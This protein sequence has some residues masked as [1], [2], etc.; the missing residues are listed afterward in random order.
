M[1]H[2]LSNLRV[3]IRSVRRHPAFIAVSVGVLALGIGVSTAI[4]SAMYSVLLKPLPYSEQN[5]LFVA[6]KG[7]SQSGSLIGEMSYPEFRDWVNRSTSFDSLAAMPTTVYGYEYVLTGLGLPIEIPSGR[8]SAS[9]FSVLRMQPLLGRVFSATDDTRGAAPT[10]I[11][12]HSLWSAQFSSDPRV[13]GTQIHLSGVA[14]TV[15]GV[16]PPDFDFPIGAKLWTPLALDIDSP[17]DR[18]ITFLQVIG[19]LKPGTTLNQAT[20]ELTAITQRVALDHPDF[21]SGHESV[22]LTPLAQFIF[23]KSGRVIYLLWGAS[24]LL[25]GIACLNLTTLLLARAIVREKEVTLRMALGASSGDLLSQFCEEALVISI[26]AALLGI[27]LARLLIF[28]L[29]RVAP[30][31]VYGL[32][33]TTLS[34]PALVVAC[35]I[36]A[37]VTLIFGLAPTAVLLRN[38]LHSS[39]KEGSARIASFRRGSTLRRIV[40]VAEVLVSL[41]LLI[42]AGLVVHSFYRTE[43]APLGFDSTNVLTANIRPYGDAWAGHGGRTD[44]YRLLI[45]RLESSPEVAHA[46]GIL[47]RP[48][49]GSVGWDTQFQFEGQDPTASRNNGTANLEVVTPN[50]F[51]A[52]GTPLLAG[53]DFSLSDS[54]SNQKVVIVNTKL[55]RERFATPDLAVNHSI[56]LGRPGGQVTWY[57][58]VGV[59]ADASYRS[60]GE[61]E[62]DVFL[63]FL[64]TSIPL[65]YI[66]VKT[67]T[68]P[69]SFS[70]TLRDQIMRIDKDQAMAYAQSLEEMVESALSG[71]RFSM[72]LFLT[73]GISAGILTVVGI[74][75]LTSESIAQRR[76]EI[77]IRMA[78]GGSEQTIRVW[79]LR[80]E[81]AYVVVGEMLGL[82]ASLIVS[83]IYGQLLSGPHEFDKYI[84]AIAAIVLFLVAVL[85]NVWPISRAT[86]VNLGRLLDE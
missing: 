47:L 72:L 67:R 19:R 13:I 58:I 18:S 35:L 26:P 56:G 78:L 62:P 61:T 46:G 1:Q 60:P 21:Y 41:M 83:R 50:Y 2:L 77:G 81:L 6:W 3:A 16:M 7:S 25:L 10:V 84:F 15:I 75:S 40:V 86:R 36:A 31:G 52:V 48:L 5:Q 53:R 24:L 33:S 34:L 17:D 9:F 54:E 80:Q 63:S 70:P 43:R 68:D 73:F 11:L 74:Y 27:V 59:V 64:Q 4:Y 79:L 20:A 45:E 57:R 42:G 51:A 14:H 32:K 76:H 23:G 85:S 66:I 82:G 49:E 65:R 30:H 55:A 44:F 38:D 37:C 29:V 28:L 39:L 8:V 69:A 71:L 22:V 12:S